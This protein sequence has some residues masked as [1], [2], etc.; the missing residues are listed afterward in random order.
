MKKVLAAAVLALTALNTAPARAND[1]PTA[2][3][4]AKAPDKQLSALDLANLDAALSKQAYIRAT[5]ENMVLKGNAEIA[6]YEETVQRIC[7]E[8]KIDRARLTEEV[9]MKTGAVKRQP[10]PKPAK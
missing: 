7:R 10:A 8:N 1:K 9:D 6:Q 3:T 4:A 2:A 5:L